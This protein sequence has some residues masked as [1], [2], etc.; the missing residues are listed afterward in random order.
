MTRNKWSVCVCGTMHCI[1]II[2]DVV[3]VNIVMSGHLSAM[4][5]AQTKDL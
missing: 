5:D 3:G 2:I 1:Q 4:D